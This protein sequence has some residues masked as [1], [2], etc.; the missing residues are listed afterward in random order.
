MISMRQQRWMKK[1]SIISTVSIKYLPGKGNEVADDLSRKLHVSV[2]QQCSRH[3]SVI[4]QAQVHTDFLME[5]QL[6]YLNDVLCN[7]IIFDIQ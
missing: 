5:L 7:D 1:L 2:I 6:S 3:I 4:S